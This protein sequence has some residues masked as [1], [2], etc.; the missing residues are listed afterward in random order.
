ME[1][2]NIILGSSFAFA[3]YVEFSPG[4]GNIWYRINDKGTRSFQPNGLLNLMT[5][6]FWNKDLWKLELLDLNWPFMTS[7]CL[8]LNHLT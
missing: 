2:V 8:L 6:P 4:M 7:C 5:S 3:M 1:H